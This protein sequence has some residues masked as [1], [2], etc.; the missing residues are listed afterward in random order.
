MPGQQEIRCLS[1]VTL[2]AIDGREQSFWAEMA[3]KALLFSLQGL[4]FPKVRLLT[5]KA[6][7]VLDHRIEHVPI[8]PIL[9]LG[10]YSKFVLKDLLSYVDTPFCLLVQSDGFVIHPAAWQ[11]EF[12]NYDYIGAPWPKTSA[13]RGGADYLLHDISEAGRVGNGGF[14]L[15]SRRLLEIC[16]K[17]DVDLFGSMAEDFVICRVLREFLVSLG[18]RFAPIDLAAKFSLELPV[19]EVPFDLEQ[20]FGFHG[21]HFEPDGLLLTVRPQV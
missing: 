13:I 14:S 12:L 6:P 3:Q 1:E 21:R 8:D 5:P 16:S 9:S 18:I 19:G 4:S 11:D 10:A 7:R 20:S 15:R 2:I 17:V